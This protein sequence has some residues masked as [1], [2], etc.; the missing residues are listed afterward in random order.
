MK[1]NEDNCPSH[2]LYELEEFVE[3]HFNDCD[4]KIR[5]EAVYILETLKEDIYYGTG[6]AQR[7]I[8]DAH[9]KIVD[10]FNKYVDTDSF[11]DH[12]IF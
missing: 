10:L 5:E 12:S 3:G 7:V 1:L 6:N 11:G 4:E 8:I 2:D 9:N